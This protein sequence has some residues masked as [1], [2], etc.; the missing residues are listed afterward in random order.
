MDAY[1]FWDCFTVGAVSGLSLEAVSPSHMFFK[2]CTS[3]DPLSEQSPVVLARSPKVSAINPINDIRGE[4][5][6][7]RLPLLKH[8]VCFKCDRLHK[9][10]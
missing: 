10:T 9:R 7:K 8:A 3:I 2:L 5:Y 1:F 6:F 4:R